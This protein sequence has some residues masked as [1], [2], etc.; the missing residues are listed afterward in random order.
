MAGYHGYKMSNNAV[1]AYDEGLVPLSKLRKQH[2]IDAGFPTLKL[3][4][5]KWLGKNGHLGSEWHHTSS[6]YNQTSFLNLSWL[7]NLDLDELEKEFKV[8]KQIKVEKPKMVEGEY[9]VWG[10]SKRKP[11][12]SYY[13]SFKGQLIGDWIHLEDGSRKKASSKWIEFK[14]VVT[15]K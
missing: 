8:S 15:A 13:K 9:P 6:W 10:G 14:E 11:R 1:K 12:I 3:N 7:E 2:L 4:F 5:V